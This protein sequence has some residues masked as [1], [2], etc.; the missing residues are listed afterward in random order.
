M[1][2]SYDRLKFRIALIFDERSNKETAPPLLEGLKKEV[3]AS[4]SL[5][6]ENVEAENDKEIV[7]KIYEEEI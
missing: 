7:K 2:R 3:K 1:A 6:R 5:M 4:F